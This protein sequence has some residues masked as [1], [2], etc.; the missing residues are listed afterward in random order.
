MKTAGV[1]RDLAYGTEI[2]LSGPLDLENEN[3][4]EESLE[5]RTSD[6]LYCKD[7]RHKDTKTLI[8]KYNIS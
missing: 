8:F 6:S 3:K 1:L 4:F 7:V 5:Q 2:L